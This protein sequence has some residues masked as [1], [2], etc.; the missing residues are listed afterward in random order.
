MTASKS[1]KIMS[2][3]HRILNL[4]LSDYLNSPFISQLKKNEKSDSYTKVIISFRIFHFIPR[5]KYFHLSQEH[6]LIFTLLAFSTKPNS[7][8]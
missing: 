7:L 6:I 4:N 2:K 8:T 5:Q 1:T 3:K